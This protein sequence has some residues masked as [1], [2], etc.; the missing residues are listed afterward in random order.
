M[1]GGRGATT[2]QWECLAVGKFGE[3]GES[4]VIRQT[5]ASQIL[6]GN[7][8]LWPKSI[9]PPNFISPVTFNSA[10]PQTLTPQNIPAIRYLTKP[11]YA[12]NLPQ[13]AVL[14]K[15]TKVS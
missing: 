3:F 11:S 9:H 8:T 14:D 7:S 6:A 1:G 4:C 5:L 15:N 13:E 2:V 10:I 12:Y